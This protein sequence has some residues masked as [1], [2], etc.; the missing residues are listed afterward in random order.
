MKKR[1]RRQRILNILV[2]LA[3]IIALLPLY[4]VIVNSLKSMMELVK[5]VFKLP[6][7]WKWFNYAY[8]FKR[9]NYVRSLINT[10]L[11][12]IVANLGLTI[13]GTMAGYWLVRHDT[14]MN[15]V[16]HVL[17]LAGAAIPFQA[18]MIPL[19][20]LMNNMHL[21]GK[22]I[23]VGIAY[24]G[25]ASSTI[26]LLTYG[27]VKS[28]PLEIEEAGIIDGCTQIGVFTRIVFP[29]LRTNV[30][31]VTI[32][33]VFWV[34]NDYLMPQLLVGNKKNLYTIQMA[35]KAFSGEN[36]VR[37]DYLLPGVILAMLVPVILFILLQKWI[38]HSMVSGAVKG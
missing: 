18:I 6:V 36:I 3:L 27:A 13:F 10:V 7:E 21:G 20:R 12:E 30:L 2:V 23:G 17:L 32:L 28:I 37:W 35:L 19:V 24:W 5:G 29:L 26:V 8:A 34:W 11:V 14:H 15:N 38:I 4:L 22:L 1:K 9:M 31:T 16:I 33:N 25:M